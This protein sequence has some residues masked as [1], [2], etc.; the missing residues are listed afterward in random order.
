MDERSSLRLFT[1][2]CPNLPIQPF[3]ESDPQP[4]PHFILR[5]LVAGLSHYTQ[6]LYYITSGA[7]GA[8]CS[9]SLNLWG[10][11]RCK[12][13]GAGAR[14]CRLGQ[15]GAPGTHCLVHGAKTAWC[16]F[17]AQEAWIPDWARSLPI[18]RKPL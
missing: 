10:P 15:A 7:P 18:L 4:A 3:L 16:I 13:F 5:G 9:G 11:G 14:W 8:K 2:P 1:I 12:Q 17:G 6:P